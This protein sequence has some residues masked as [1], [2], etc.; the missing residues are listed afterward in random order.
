MGLLKRYNPNDILYLTPIQVGNEQLP[1]GRIRILYCDAKG[2]IGSAVIED[3]VYELAKSYVD[4]LEQANKNCAILGVEITPGKHVPLAVVISPEQVY[5]LD[6]ILEHALKRGE[7]PGVLKRYPK[8][9]I[10]L[11]EGK[12]E[13]LK[14]LH[15]Q[16]TDYALSEEA[17]EVLNR[18]ADYTEEGVEVSIPI[19]KAEHRYPLVILK[20]LPLNDQTPLNT[21]RL[22]ILDNDGD[23]AIIRVPLATIDDAEKTFEEWKRA[24]KSEGCIICLRHSDGFIMAQIEI[25]KAQRKA[26]GIITKH[27]EETGRGEQPISTDAQAVL[28]K[29]RVKV[30]S[31]GQNAG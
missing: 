12:R 17:P 3:S 8:E 15:E 21:Q 7:V 19:Y 26:L 30:S 16:A 13:E 24:N 11:G 31:I 10:Q 28:T 25:S 4:E 5:A 6:N 1:E 29:A 20:R 23:L 18:L 9:I 27:F 22:L 14:K 2:N